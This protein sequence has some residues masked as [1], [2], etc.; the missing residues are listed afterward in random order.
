[1]STTRSRPADSVAALFL[2]LAT[3]LTAA[4]GCTSRSARWPEGAAARNVQAVGYSDLDGRPG[5]K[6]AIREVNGR[7]YLY[8]GH[9]WHRGWSI[10]DVTDPASPRIVRF[11][12]GPE[13]TWTIQ[14]ELAGNRMVTALEKIA[15]GWGGDPNKRF[16]EG[17]LIWDVSD[18]INPKTLG[19]Y[20]TRASGTHRNFY[21]GGRY[22]HLS[23]AAPGYDGQ[24]YE[25]VDVAD[26]AKPVEVGRW[27]MP[28]QDVAHGEKPPRP[29]IS[30]HGPPYVSGNLAFLSYGSGGMVIL[31][32]SDVTRPKLV[33]T[34]S[35]SPPFLDNIGVHTVQ[36]FQ[37]RRLAFV[38]SESIAEDCR[39]A[40]PQASIVDISDPAQPLLL[41]ILPRPEPPPGLPYNDFCG[42]GGRFGPH[43]VN[44]HQHSGDIEQQRD[45]FYLTYFNA[46]L[47]VFDVR[48]P[49]QPHEVG[50]FIPPDPQRRYGPLPASK[51]VTEVEDVLVDRRGYIYI[52]DK[53]QG[54]WILRYMGEA[55]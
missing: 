21:S 1:M 25:I 8:L 41:S 4:S 15:P 26:P 22:V 28:G 24:I 55:A 9:L 38:N 51:L 48:N 11:I 52:T 7:W 27:W 6:M 34:L 40:L 42:K 45:L 13:N 46:G 35:Y 39:E 23:A 20:F 50:Y 3:M 37:N 30:L 16:D 2:V 29:G 43:N 54:L 19:H 49:R 10:V 36:P 12:P 14:M 44:E 31:D 33:S 5:F 32:I 18:P 47:R 53:N 17:V